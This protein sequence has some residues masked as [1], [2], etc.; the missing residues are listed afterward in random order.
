MRYQWLEFTFPDLWAVVKIGRLARTLLESAL[1]KSALAGK[2]R[3]WRHL[4]IPKRS[5]GILR[6]SSLCGDFRD[7]RKLQAIREYA[8]DGV[9]TTI[10]RGEHGELREKLGLEAR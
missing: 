1:L 10:F 6:A 5:V 2:A 9:F 4:Q 7:P 3:A 8:M